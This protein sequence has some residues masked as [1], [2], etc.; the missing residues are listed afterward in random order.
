MNGPFPSTFTPGDLVRPKDA[1]TFC[2]VVERIDHQ[3]GQV[4]CVRWTG[5]EAKKQCWRPDQLVL[6]KEAM[7][8]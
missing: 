2:M 5:G 8:R 6:L 1:Y 4:V 7:S 3:T